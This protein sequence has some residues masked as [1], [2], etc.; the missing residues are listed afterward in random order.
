MKP[1]KA[2][3]VAVLFVLAGCGGESSDGFEKRVADLTAIKNAI[4]EYHKEH[5]K[6]PV[7]SGKSQGWDGLNSRWGESKPEWI[8]GLAPKYITSLPAD[9]LND[10]KS[11][12]QY[13]YR[14]NGVD[15]KLISH[16]N[17]GDPANNDCPEV[18]K[19]YPE[20]VD[21]K[22]NCWSYGFWSAGAKDW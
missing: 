17:A 1:R 4:L 7:S 13:L 22:R 16:H 8:A 19:K 11:Q 9:P 20:M 18:K 12:S 2:L 3:I 10:A 5:Q 21:S 14:S 6:F 15:F